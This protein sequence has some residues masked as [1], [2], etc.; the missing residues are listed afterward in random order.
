[1]R[2]GGPFSLRHGA[3]G[4]SRRLARI[5]ERFA[6]PSRIVFLPYLAGERTP[7]NDPEARAAF[8]GLDNTTTAEDI[9]QAVLE[10]VAFTLIDAQVAL[11]AAGQAM[12]P[13]AAIGGGP[14]HPLWLQLIARALGA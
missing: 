12:R 10:G 5:E 8:F 9:G 1:M 7:H 11:K 13:V 2:R 14:R 4:G 3:G 6:G